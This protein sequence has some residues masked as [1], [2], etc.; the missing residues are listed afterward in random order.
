M[1]GRGTDIL[2][3]PGVAARGGL[4][5]ILTEY[6][7]SRRVDRQLL[8]RCARQGDPGTCQAI[9]SLDDELYRVHAPAASRIAASLAARWPGRARPIVRVLTRL[10]QA[11]AERRNVFARQQTL[12]FDLQIDKTLA[13]SGRGE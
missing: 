1:A 11:A 12:K 5:V 6:H 2:L 10:A 13:F 8:G 3:G 4:H 7:E 9:V